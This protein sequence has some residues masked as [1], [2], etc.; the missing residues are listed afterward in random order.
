MA[1][2]AHRS[3]ATRHRRASGGR[4][5]VIQSV[6]PFR[7][8]PCQFIAQTQVQG[9]LAPEFPRIAKVESAV[10]LFSGC[11]L[12]N[13]QLSGGLIAKL[14]SDPQTIAE[15]EVRIIISIDLA[16]SSRH[17]RSPRSVKRHDSA[18]DVRL[19][20]VVKGLFE[21]QPE[22]ECVPSMHFGELRG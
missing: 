1:G 15:Q 18:A 8:R 6:E 4:V 10:S 20:V 16:G 17:R 3:A 9:Q 7:P 14:R 12:R 2:A 22:S 5:P 11:W 19:I 13:C 21:L